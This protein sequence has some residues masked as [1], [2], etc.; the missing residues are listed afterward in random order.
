MIEGPSRDELL[1]ATTAW[2]E[3]ASSP[4][5]GFHRRVAA[6]ALG[7]VSRELAQ[8]PAAEAA[9][10]MRM[11]AILGCDGDYATLNAALAEALRKGTV[12]AEDPAV[13]DHLRRAAL[14]MLAIDQPRYRHELSQGVEA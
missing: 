8:W 5:E 4:V 11:Q 6:N 13:F 2:L 3:D 14:A 1:Q 7:M 9:A 12:S 10:V